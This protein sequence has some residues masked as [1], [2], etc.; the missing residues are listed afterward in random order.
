MAK[1]P[2]ICLS[3]VIPIIPSATSINLHILWISSDDGYPILH[4]HETITLVESHLGSHE[5]IFGPIDGSPNRLWYAYAQLPMTDPYNYV[6]IQAKDPEGNNRVG[7]NFF[8]PPRSPPFD[9]VITSPWSTTPTIDT[10][11]AHFFPA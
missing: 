8:E 1:K 6:Q 10:I 4:V 7:D 5:F 3:K 11:V 9:Q 2:P